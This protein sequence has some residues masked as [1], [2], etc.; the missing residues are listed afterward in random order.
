MT[1]PMVRATEPQM[2]DDGT[3]TEGQDTEG[4]NMWI[5]PSSG[6]EISRGRNADVERQ[7]REH[8]RQKDAKKNR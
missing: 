3:G 4:H 5:N 6:R 7:V 8:Q 1:K 2:P